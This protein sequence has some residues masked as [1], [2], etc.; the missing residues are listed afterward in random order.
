MKKIAILVIAA[1]NQPVYIHYIKNYWSGLIEY[2]N[3]EKPNVDVFLLLENGTVCDVFSNI[4]DNV[5]ED[6]T[7]DIDR[8]CEPRFQAPGLPGILTKTVY[9]FELLHERYDVFFRTNLSSFIKISAFEAYVQSRESIGY[10][11]AWIWKEALRDD[12]IAHNKV[13][14]DKSIKTLSELNE[15]KG[16]TFFSGAGYFLSAEEAR[17]LVQRKGS[18]RYDIIDDVSIGLMFDKYEHIPDLST[19]VEPSM[20]A[21]EIVRIIQTSTS[22]HIRLQHFPVEI[23]QEVWCEL[24]NDPIWK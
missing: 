21:N 24:K 23:A 20:P 22:P 7:A 9:A 3:K 11:G 19:I 14:P 16:N 17:I 10:S 2:T 8:L 15:Y 5:I 4:I 13:G 6:Q 12:L 1:T 18:I